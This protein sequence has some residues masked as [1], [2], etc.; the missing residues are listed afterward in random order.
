MVTVLVRFI[1]SIVTMTILPFVMHAHT[2]ANSAMGVHFC[3]SMSAY[4]QACLFAD[5]ADGSEKNM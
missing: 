4:L 3:I 5:L 2:F 1:Q